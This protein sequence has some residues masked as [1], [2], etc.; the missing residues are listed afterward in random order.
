LEHAVSPPV[1]SAAVNKILI[2]MESLWLSYRLSAI[3]HQ[4]LMLIADSR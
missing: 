3:G 2:R 4:P 1:R